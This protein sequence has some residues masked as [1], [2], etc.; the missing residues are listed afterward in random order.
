MMKKIL[1]FS[2]LIAILSSC[3]EEDPIP[4][5]DSG[6]ATPQ[7]K[8]NVLLMMGSDIQNPG[9]AVY[10][11][12]R[13]QAL[14]EYS[15]SIN[16]LHMVSTAVGGLYEPDGDSIMMN[17]QSPTAPFFVL[18]DEEV[19]SADLVNKTKFAL[20]K[21][22]LLAVT[23][24]VS[25]NDTAWIIDHKVK[26]F[27]DTLTSDI[28]IDTY[29][30]GKSKARSYTTEIPGMTLDLRMAASQDLIKHPPL[31]LPHESQWDKDVLTENE[32]RVLVKKGTTFFYENQFLAK[33][34]S[35]GTWGYPLGDY[36]PFGGEYYKGDII[37][38]DDTPIRQYIR[39]FKSKNAASPD[40]VSSTKY[41]FMSI[42]WVRDPL[43]GSFVH[44]NSYINS[45][46][47]TVK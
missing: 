14:D 41:T 3:G 21:K 26:F 19:F 37:G 17:F 31:P 40:Y 39:K 34:D 28:Y 23:N 16:T 42:V 24:Q 27:M 46:T 36:W 7:E 38:T 35:T 18:D 4:T 13:I 1:L 45:A 29:M 8:Y 10:E 15:G 47:F 9:S 6:P 44:A 20:R 22:P 2:A 11:E 33:F 5:V 30:L 43:T 25:Q 12:A 32:K